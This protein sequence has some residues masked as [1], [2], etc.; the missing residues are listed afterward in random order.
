M[1]IG[2]W[3]FDGFPSLFACLIVGIVR[4]AI[5]EGLCSAPAG[6]V[7]RGAF[8]TRDGKATEFFGLRAGDPDFLRF[9]GDAP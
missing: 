6:F 3:D 2:D 4:L 7:P 8:A 1:P 5:A 9:A